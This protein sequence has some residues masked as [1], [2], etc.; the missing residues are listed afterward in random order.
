MTQ[1]CEQLVDKN[2]SG[3]LKGYWRRLHS[4]YPT[5]RD[6]LVPRNCSENCDTWQV[7]EPLTSLTSV[8]T[9]KPKL[10]QE[11]NNNNVSPILFS[12]FVICW[13][14][15]NLKANFSKY[16]NIYRCNAGYILW[17]A[18][19]RSFNAVWWLKLLLVLLDIQHVIPDHFYQTQVRSL[20]CLVTQSLTHFIIQEFL[21]FI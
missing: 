10:G 14:V 21:F 7:W 1:P 13:Y 20:S 4:R 15:A 12:K 5:I 3:D 17:R 19:N 6:L 18:W 8:N 16:P 2:T 9:M 11:T